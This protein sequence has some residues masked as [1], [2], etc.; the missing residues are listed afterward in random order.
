[1][2]VQIDARELQ[3][4][5]QRHELFQRLPQSID[6]RSHHQIDL[7]PYHGVVEP[8]IARSPIPSLRIAA[9]G[10]SLAS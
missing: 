1:M 8:V 3:I 9:W 2:Q 6:G 7:P 4:R 5:K 10:S